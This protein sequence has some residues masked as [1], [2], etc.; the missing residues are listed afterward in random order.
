MRQRLVYFFIAAL[1]GIMVMG[2]CSESSDTPTDGDIQTDGD[3][4][5]DGDT[6]EEES[7]LAEEE[8]E[9]EEEAVPVCLG[10]D[11]AAP[12]EDIFAEYCGDQQRYRSATKV[13]LDGACRS[14][15]NGFVGNEAAGDMM[16]VRIHVD[17]PTRLT[18][19]SAKFKYQGAGRMHIMADYGRSWPDEAKDITEPMDFEITADNT[20]TYIEFEIADR[21]IDVH[22]KD[23]F[24]VVYEHLDANPKLVV[25]G[26][27]EKPRSESRYKVQKLIDQWRQQGQA[28][29]W[30]AMGG[31]STSGYDHFALEVEG[32]AICA[33]QHTRYF[34]DISET[35]FGETFGGSRTA[36]MDINDDGWDDI[37]T[38]D[39]AHIW[40][41]NGDNTFTDMLE[42]SGLED[43][44]SRFVV[45]GDVNNDGKLDL[46]VG[47]YCDPGNPGTEENPDL[48]NLIML[49]NG[50]F[51]FTKVENSGVEN[52]DPSAAGGFADYDLDGNLDLFYGNWLEQYPYPPAV[53][54][55]LL[56]GNGD[57][58]FTDV[59]EAAGMGDQ[60]NENQPCYGAV[61]GDYTNDGYPD[62]LVSNYG[63]GPNFLWT[64][65]GDGTFVDMGSELGV[66]KDENGMYGGNTFG[67]DFGDINNDGLL[68][69]Y[70]SEISHPRYHPFSDPSR[71]LINLG[72]VT[73]FSYLDKTRDLGIVYDEGEIEPTFV[74]WDND[75][76]LDLY[77]GTLYTGHYARLY[78]QEGNGVFVDVTYE[79]G[80]I[81]HDS[82]NNSWADFD[83]DGDMDLLAGQR[84]G[85]AFMH[86]FR[87]DAPNENHWMQVRLNSASSNA[88]AI[89]ARVEVTTCERTQIREVNSGKGHNSS[90]KSFWQHFGLGQNIDSPTVTIKWPS[91]TVQT[92]NDVPIDSFITVTEGSD[93]YSVEAPAQ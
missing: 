63:Y 71:L 40:R 8:A 83:R 65:Q 34:N 69:I 18:K 93:D 61:W 74:D 28:F 45:G 19:I 78:R 75:G 62:L 85:G 73:S 29:V 88:D 48:P 30:G 39:P 77:V 13:R 24:W 22:P 33:D 14:T 20:E 57:G 56:K 21:G 5:V 68:D 60:G 47:T 7:D 38:H 82:T 37:I 4:N 41:N 80:I 17:E 87:N 27:C 51:T 84:G 76:D 36:W 46:F 2:G 3:E 44:K 86:L 91:G 26:G 58:T 72:E 43:T 11:D 81:V 15:R 1:I 59:T 35:A 50:D 16:A 32:R 9:A 49:G 90:Q 31:D 53:A 92:L 52:L 10:W 64:N 42:G 55:V 6:V 25:V 12:A 54:D 66:D 79:A 70:L 67:A 23:F 89:G